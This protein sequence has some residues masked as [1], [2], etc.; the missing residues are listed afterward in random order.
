MV[1]SGY[2]WFWMVMDGYGLVT[3]GYG[4]IM[5]DYQCLR[6]VR[7]KTSN[8]L[9]RSKEGGWGRWGGSIMKIF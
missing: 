9:L 2:W 8:E 7:N 6:V 1:T 5:G 3:S 4:V